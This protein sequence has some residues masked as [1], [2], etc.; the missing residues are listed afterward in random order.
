MLQI[1]NSLI[2]W[3]T[4]CGRPRHRCTK[5]RTQPPIAWN[6]GIS[7][8]TKIYQET[9]KM[10]PWSTYL[11]QCL[12]YMKSHQSISEMLHELQIPSSW[13]LVYCVWHP[14]ADL[15][16]ILRSVEGMHV[17]Q[18]RLM[19][20]GVGGAGAGS[21]HCMQGRIQMWR[22]A[23]QHNIWTF[24]KIFELFIIWFPIVVRY[25]YYNQVSINVTGWEKKKR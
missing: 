8:L 6:C 19:G 10:R 18:G 23:P 14:P 13:L 2:T 9:H 17:A 15:W 3:R 24:R 22:V 25:T 11:P 4:T 21:N 16:T 1:T 20:D 12:W 7:G 5:T